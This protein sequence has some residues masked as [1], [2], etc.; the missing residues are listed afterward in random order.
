MMRVTIMT[1]LCAVGAAT[2]YGQT[3]L[4]GVAEFSPF[5]VQSLYAIDAATGAAT[6]IGS[7]GLRR[8]SGLDWNS[9]NSRLVALTGDG[10]QYAIDTATGASTLLVDA[11]FGVPEGSIAF[12]AGSA[13]TTIFDDLHIWSGSAWQLIG[14]ANLSTS[15]D[16]S[17]LDFGGG[18]LL[19]LATNGAADDQ[20]L[21]Y[22]AATGAATVIGA[23]GTN[24]QTVAGLAHDFLANAWYMSDGA[25][26]Y[27][28][29]ADTGAAT[30]IGAHGIAGFSGLAY[31][32]APGVLTLAAA[33]LLAA[34][35]R[36]R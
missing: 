34:A 29:N 21:S 23:T 16:A 13:Y 4:F 1:A 7:T 8:I 28:L 20:L 26:L 5:G 19:A 32:P 36:R 35:R 18:R 11:D 27:T 25:S 17:G 30:L 31:V 2:A 15:S 24:A 6:A 12:A 9:A 14:P 3:G 33:G 10:D 22:D